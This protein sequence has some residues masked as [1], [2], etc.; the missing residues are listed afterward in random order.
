MPP[1][2]NDQILEVGF[3]GGYLLGTLLDHIGENG[4]VTGVD[5]SEAMLKYCSRRYSKAISAERLN[6]HRI[7]A[8]RL[9]FSDKSFQKV[10]T[11]NTLFYFD[12]PIKVFT[13]CHRVL[14]DEG[15]LLVCFTARESLESKGFSQCGMKLYDP[16][17]LEPMLGESGFSDMVC[18]SAWHG[19]R[20]FYCII[21][22]R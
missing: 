9:P 18:H 4:V 20:H 5:T 12:D 21:A 2:C 10:Y 14:H 7:A 17:Q 6:L 3:G 22:R 15:K 8:S 1:E 13:E 11:V 16:A 19:D